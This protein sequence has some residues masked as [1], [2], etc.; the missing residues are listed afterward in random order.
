MTPRS[1]VARGPEDLIA[2]VPYLLGFHPEESLVLVTFGAPTG[3]FHAR[4][5]LPQGAEERA[6]MVQTL[7]DAVSAN[8]AVVTAVLVFSADAELARASCADLVPALQRAGASVLDAVRADGAHWWSLL[9]DDSQPHPYDLRSHPFTAERV[10]DGQAAFTNRAE[11]ASSLVGADPDD[12]RLVSS[13]ADGVTDELLAGGVDEALDV[14]RTN[15]VWLRDRLASGAIADAALSVPDA[16]RMLV[17]VQLAAMRDVACA[18]LSRETA[19]DHVRLWR[20]LLRRAPRDLVPGVAA[21]LGLAA[22]LD[23]DGALAWCAVDRCQEVDPE[24]SLARHLTGLLQR[25]VPPTTWT[26]IDEGRLPL[27]TGLEQ[28]S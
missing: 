13:A 18:A 6:A 2:L 12:T 25:A 1:Y 15:A 14:A 17:L 28:A 16:G 4:T 7:C 11:L 9:D 20:E 24:Q 27:L 5:D 22:W 23:G 8:G 10:L 26:P 3:S 21:L 19:H